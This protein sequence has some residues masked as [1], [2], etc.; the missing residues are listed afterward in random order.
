MKPALIR[1]SEESEEPGLCPRAGKAA[2]THNTHVATS[3]NLQF[4]RFPWLTVN[5]RLPLAR[6]TARHRFPKS[7]VTEP[8]MLRVTTVGTVLMKSGMNSMCR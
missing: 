5:S 1:Y 3:P 2:H 7:S 4:V 8:K 6:L